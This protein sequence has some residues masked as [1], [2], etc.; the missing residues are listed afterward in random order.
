MQY[1]KVVLKESF[2]VIQKGNNYQ[3]HLVIQMRNM[4]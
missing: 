2:H 1:E 3:I 4:I